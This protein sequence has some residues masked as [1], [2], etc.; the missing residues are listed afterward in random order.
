MNRYKIIEFKDEPSEADIKILHECLKKLKLELSKLNDDNINFHKVFF[1]YK[2]MPSEFN[3]DQIEVG[4]NNIFNSFIIKNKDCGQEY[5]EHY[6][7][8]MSKNIEDKKFA[9]N[10]YNIQYLKEHHLL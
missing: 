4:I 1:D 5:K 9:L 2:D 6:I 7:I 8:D 3:E 10:F